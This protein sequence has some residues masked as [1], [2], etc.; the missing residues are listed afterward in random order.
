MLLLSQKTIFSLGLKSSAGMVSKLGGVMGSFA[1]KTAGSEGA[2]I[3][4]HKK[5]FFGV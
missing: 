4:C 1:L 3:S 2:L 5:I